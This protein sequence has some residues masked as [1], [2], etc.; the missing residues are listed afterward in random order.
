MNKIT[1]LSFAILFSLTVGAQRPYPSIDDVAKFSKSTTFVV[2]EDN[3]FSFFNPEIKAVVQ[4][5]WT[6][7][8]Y[9]FISTAEF[10]QKWTDPSYS[11]LVL[12]MTNFSNDKSGSSYDFM[13]L[14]L[15]ADVDNLD[16]LPEFC[17]IPLSFSGDE[18]GDYT[19]KLGLVVRFLQQHVETLINNPSNLALKYLKY[20]NKNT[21]EVKNKTILA[22]EVDMDPSLNT[23]DKIKVYYPY[24]FKI[25][26]E[27][28]IIKAVEEKTPGILILHKVGPAA[29]KKTGTCMK[30]LIG[31][32]DAIMYYYDTHLVDSKNPN[33]ML[34]SDLKRIGR[35]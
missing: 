16:Q 25:V 9:K 20:Y 35:Y 14:L 15:G 34:I 22:R 31:T 6:V 23:E 11:F 5:Y 3:P 28:A 24:V 12:T 4:K 26:D 1:L 27:E 32:D 7:T 33:G 29:D 17:S 18:E 13:N 30:M 19:Y 21:P 10:N 2:L 8:P